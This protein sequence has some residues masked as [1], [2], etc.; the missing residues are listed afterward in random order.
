MSIYA[1]SDLHLSFASPKPMD[2]FNPVWKDHPRKLRENWDRMVSPSDI[3]LLPGDLSWGMT[4]ADARPDLQFVEERPGRKVLTRGN[5]DFW[6]QRKATNR[7]QKTIDKSFTFLQGT[8]VVMDGVGIT[9]TRGW[10][11]EKWMT[12]TEGDPSIQA[13]VAQSEKVLAREL[14]YLESGLAS[15]PDSVELKIVMLHFPPFDE[16]LQPNN[17]T[18]VLH[19]Y[20]VDIVVYGHVHLT[21]GAWLEGQMDGIRYVM[22]SA[23]VANF[24][25]RLIIP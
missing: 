13:E 3:V 9:G 15:I 12:M 5:H 2:I 1:I 4:L 10:R 19:K 21:G 11:L 7:I 24:V 6:W 8:S 23:D 14:K 20:N 17:F 16:R 25:P 18:A 22:A